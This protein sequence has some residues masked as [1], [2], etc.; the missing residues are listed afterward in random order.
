VNAI[1]NVTTQFRTLEVTAL[2]P[3]HDT[4]MGSASKKRQGV[5]RELHLRVKTEQNKV[6]MKRGFQKRK[7]HLLNA[8]SYFHDADAVPLIG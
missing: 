6:K 5:Y 7:K 1:C 2:C 8:N 3:G 4:T